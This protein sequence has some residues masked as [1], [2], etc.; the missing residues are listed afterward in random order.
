[1]GGVEKGGP[2]EK[3]GAKCQRRLLRPDL[4][5]EGS[6]RVTRR[7]F[8]FEEKSDG[9]CEKKEHMAEHSL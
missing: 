9:E 5:E 3:G 1:V 7:G 6:L 4:A 8:Q 2:H